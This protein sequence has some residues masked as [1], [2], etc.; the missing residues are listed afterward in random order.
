MDGAVAWQRGQLPSVC[1]QRLICSHPPHPYRLAR[2]PV[3]SGSWLSVS[4]VLGG[5]CGQLYESVQ[6][7]TVAARIQVDFG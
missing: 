6:S 2:C 1:P 4:S 7:C 5:N 3:A